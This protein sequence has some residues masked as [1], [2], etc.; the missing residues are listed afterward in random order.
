MGIEQHQ[1][2]FVPRRPVG[3]FCVGAVTC[4]TTDPPPPRVGLEYG[5]SRLAA[6]RQARVLC[7]QLSASL[8]M[9]LYLGSALR[10][11]R[12]GC[13]NS[14]EQG[15]SNLTLGRWARFKGVVERKGGF[16]CYVGKQGV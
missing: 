4:A 16:M 5:G 12:G 6:V 15:T 11:F 7:R 1:L 3:P 9:A 8:D 14:W 13:P 2:V 10:F